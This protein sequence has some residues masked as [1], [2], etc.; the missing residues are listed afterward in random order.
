MIR[1]YEAYLVFVGV[2]W[3]GSL[4]ALT[5]GG[6][7]ILN[8]AASSSYFSLI[9][10]EFLRLKKRSWFKPA[11]VISVFGMFLLL[12]IDLFLLT[13]DVYLHW[14]DFVVLFLGL[15]LIFVRFL[16]SGRALT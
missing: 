1:F 14:L 2:I 5:Q 11:M 9:F 16:M 8:I 7:L 10:L 3:L 15:I 6:H 13:T 12:T 4:M